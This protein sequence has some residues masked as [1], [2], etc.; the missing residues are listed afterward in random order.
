MGV[1]L[2]LVPPTD[3]PVPLSCCLLCPGLVLVAGEG[4]GGPHWGLCVRGPSRGGRTANNRSLLS[5]ARQESHKQ[6]LFQIGLRIE[7][8][9]GCVSEGMNHCERAAGHRGRISPTC[10]P[11]DGGQLP[12]CGDCT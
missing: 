4:A 10:T 2:G 5:V 7:E 3:P 6:I 8:S 11:S 1:L 12:L 9:S